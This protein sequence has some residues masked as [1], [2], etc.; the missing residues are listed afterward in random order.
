MMSAVFCINP[1]PDLTVALPLAGTSNVNL[2]VNSPEWGVDSASEANKWFARIDGEQ[3][4]DWRAGCGNRSASD[5][6][7]RLGVGWFDKAMSGPYRYP[8]KS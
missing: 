8:L 2:P 7:V 1:N 6:R 4:T 3:T 5:A